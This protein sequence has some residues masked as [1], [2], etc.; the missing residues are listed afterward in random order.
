MISFLKP[1]RFLKLNKNRFLLFIFHKIL[2]KTTFLL[3]DTFYKSKTSEYIYTFF[4]FNFFKMKI[5]QF[6]NFSQKPSFLSFKVLIVLL[7][8]AMSFTSCDNDDEEDDDT[9]KWI[10]RKTLLN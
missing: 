1:Q 9:W 2:N 10:L 3:V 7:V 4:Q 6:L 8:C 5:V